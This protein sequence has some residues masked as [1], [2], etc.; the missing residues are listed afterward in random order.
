M[1]T[2][3]LW[4][5]GDKLFSQPL[6]QL[7]SSQFLIRQ[8]YC[9]L[10]LRYIYGMLVLEKKKNGHDYSFNTMIIKAMRNGELN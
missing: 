6:T 1:S 4:T 10:F 2:S 5:W 7:T 3:F 8:V 9:R